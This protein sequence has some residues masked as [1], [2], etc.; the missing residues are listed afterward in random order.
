MIVGEKL[1]LYPTKEQEEIFR[2]FWFGYYIYIIYIS[3]RFN[4]LDGEVWQS[5]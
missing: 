1:R 4:T 5:I 2:F 3:V